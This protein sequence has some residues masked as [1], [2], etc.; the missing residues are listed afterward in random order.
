MRLTEL[1]ESKDKEVAEVR[2]Q[3]N[4]IKD[5]TR[6]NERILP[7][8]TFLNDIGI[9]IDQLPIYEDI[10]VNLREKVTQHEQLKL[11]YEELKTKSEE[12]EKAGRQKEE[13]MKA[14]VEELDK[15]IKHLLP[16]IK[17]H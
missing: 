13:A 6:N 14:K 16:R 9:H 7:T 3:F 4:S 5:K 2:A 12:T 11:K 8:P 10:Y 17:D 15:T 1:Q